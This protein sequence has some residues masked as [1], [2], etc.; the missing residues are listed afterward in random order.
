MKD[1]YTIKEFKTDFGTEDQCLEY[2]FHQRFGQHDHCPH[3][4]KKFSYSKVSSKKKYKCAHC[5][6][7]IAP[8]AGTIFHKSS[9][10]LVL[11]F[12]A[13]FLFSVSKNGVSAKELERQLGVTYKTAWRIA[14]QVRTLFEDDLEDM[15]KGTVEVDET[16]MGGKEKNKHS[17]KKL[18]QGRGAVGKIAIIGAKQR[19]G[20]IIAKPIDK[21][22]R[23]TLHEFIEENTDKGATILTDEHRGYIGLKDRLH[24]TVCHSMGE[25][26]NGQ[27]HTNGIESFWSLFKRGYHGTFHH[28]SKKHMHRYVDEFAGRHNI[29]YK[30]TMDQMSDVVKGFDNKR[31]RYK[32]LIAV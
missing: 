21:T 10:P 6:G 30:N 9:T 15:L 20:R 11:W 3:C 19:D 26:V 13:I 14:K 22:D 1:R 28:I 2:V 18:K 16:Y 5:G 7:E 23:E 24:H 17:S 8:L 29:R 32:D 4:E 25:Y 12:H 27:A 31:L